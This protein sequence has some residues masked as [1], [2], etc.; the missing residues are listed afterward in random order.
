MRHPTGWDSLAAGLEERG[1]AGW[2]ILNLPGY[3]I[4]WKE[5]VVALKTEVERD[6]LIDV[7]G[8]LT[9]FGILSIFPFLLF[10]VSLAAV[11]IDPVQAQLL[12][13]ELARVAPPA[14][15]EILGGRL[16][17]L[18][19]GGSPE[20][21]TLSA[22]GAIWSASAGIAALMRALNRVYGVRESRPLWKTR[23]IALL[24]TLGAAIF[25]ILATLVAVAVPVV[26]QAIGGRIGSLL[27]WL[28]FPVAGLLMMFVWAMLYYVL[29]DVRQRFRFIT[30]GSVAGVIVWLAAS[31]GFSIYVRSF[32]SFE[33]SYGALG[34]VIVLLVWMWISSMVVLVG[35]E[36]NA[37]LEPRSPAGRAFAEGR[38]E[39]AG[40]VLPT[41][42]AARLAPA[43]E[44]PDPRR[45]GSTRP[46]EE[47]HDEPVAAASPLR[48]PIVWVLAASLLGLG[49]LLGRLTA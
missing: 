2:P 30:P 37:I 41:A 13:D 33:V 1:S 34:G 14:V 38:G 16:R 11:V 48:R 43:P 45:P 49:F 9:F 20:L 7:A 21:L 26:A 25:S 40:P 29:P 17:A 10:L 36:I 39:E 31:T 23:G 4:G 32:S 12:I 35:A 5:F 3:G 22:L 27:L 18:G 42:R 8:S 24:T 44:A 19:E 47:A 15:V 6:D 46:P 28:R